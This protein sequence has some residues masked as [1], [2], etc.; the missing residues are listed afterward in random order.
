MRFEIDRALVLL[1]VAREL[2]KPGMCATSRIGSRTG[3]RKVHDSVEA[4]VLVHYDCRCCFVNKDFFSCRA[5]MRHVR[6]CRSAGSRFELESGLRTSYSTNNNENK[7][8]IPLILRM[9]V[10]IRTH[11]RLASNK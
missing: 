8:I 1:A 6:I 10:N 7:I 4:N 2:R 11:A 5:P 3:A 9:Y